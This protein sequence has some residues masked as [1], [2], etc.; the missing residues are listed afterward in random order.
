MDQ[1][2]VDR[3]RQD[4][5]LHRLTDAAR[6]GLFGSHRPMNTFAARLLEQPWHRALEC[7]GYS[8][9][10]AN[11]RLVHMPG[12]FV[13]VYTSYRAIE[14]GTH[15]RVTVVFERELSTP[16]TGQY[17]ITIRANVSVD[18]ALLVLKEIAETRRAP[19]PALI[20]VK[21]CDRHVSV[22]VSD[23]WFATT[24]IGETVARCVRQ[25]RDGTLPV[26]VTIHA[27][28]HFPLEE[29]ARLLL[30]LSDVGP[31]NEPL[32]LCCDPDGWRLF[33]TMVRQSFLLTSS[34]QA[35]HDP[36]FDHSLRKIERVV[37]SNAT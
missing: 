27:M 28:D 3:F 16:S 25:S 9:S 10:R 8:S 5:A 21:Q 24:A 11:F 32:R 33:R 37:C 20:T 34:S 4:L 1:E 6:G 36:P 2:K 18:S 35:H 30:E 22:E 12:F 7:G 19:A 17:D 14:Q 29:G 23:G 15:D 31:P 13:C 26:V